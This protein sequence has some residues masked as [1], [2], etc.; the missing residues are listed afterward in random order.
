V[1]AVAN[2][3]WPGGE[4]VV[5]VLSADVE[6]DGVP[7]FRFQLHDALLAGARDIVVD[8]SSLDALPSAA[9]AAMLTAHR[10][11]RRRGGQVVLRRPSRRALDQLHR[12]GLWRV[13]E[14]EA[15]APLA[16]VPPRAKGCGL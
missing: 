8:A 4:P 12:T 11:C 5:V 15:L 14:V 6:R 13:L 10:A 3:A 9:I 16:G 2:N 7:D 1:F